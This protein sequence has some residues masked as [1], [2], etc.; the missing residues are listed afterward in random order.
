[1]PA[2]FIRAVRESGYV[3]VSSALAELIDNSLQARATLVD[4]RVDRD[5]DRNLP[6]ISIEDNGGGMD[7]TELAACLR[8]GGSSRFD[9]RDSFG[10]FGMGLPA[11]SLSQAR[12]T[13]VTAWRPGSAAQSVTLDIDAVVAGRPANLTPAPG[14]VGQSPSGCRVVWHD[15]DRIEY[16]RLA[17]LER[18][19]HKD[20][21]RMFRRFLTG[22]FT[23]RING[24]QVEAFDPT[25]RSTTISGHTA[26]LAFEPLRYEIAT[27]TKSTSNVTVTFTM[28]PVAQWHSLDNTTKRRRGIVGGGGG[29]SILRAGREIANGWH[30]MGGK[31]KE[32]YDDWWRCEIEFHPALDEHFGITVN[33]QGIRPSATLR[34]ALEPELE[35]VARILN[36]RVRQAFE[37]VKFEAAVQSSCRI[38]GAADADL[39]VI[40]SDGRV[41]GAL[42]YRLGANQLT[43]DSMFDLTL[44]QRLLDVT[45]NTDHPG[46]AALYRPLQEMGD[47]ATPVRTA[48]DLL[49]LSFARSVA[50]AG[51]HQED[52]RS[53]LREWGTTYG[54]MLEKS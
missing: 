39:P 41:H 37:E 25:M 4:I 1:M 26:R 34:E 19:L 28:L 6:R 29:V 5:A 27:H 7:T 43:G 17:W 15:C 12:R 49:L 40:R 44:R 13:E 33:K 11:A 42:S 18:A 9:A 10:R 53:L 54:R 35:S 45:M 2:N 24:S 14:A 20:L 23:L 8:F 30:L 16:Q 47:A 36:A 50:A 22:T 31:R 38:A 48:L 51:P 3:S 21:G 32:N 52:Y 46:Y